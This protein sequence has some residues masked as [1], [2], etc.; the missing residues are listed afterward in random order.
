MIK[1]N[2]G[3]KMKTILVG[4]NAKYIHPNLAIRLLKKNTTYPVDLKEFTIK[5]DNKTIINYLSNY[6]VIAF[7]CY[8]WNIEKIKAI[9]PVLHGKTIVLGGPEVSYNATY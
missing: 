1:W 7:S 8:I 6:D 3:D 9:L 5:D 4:I 2:L